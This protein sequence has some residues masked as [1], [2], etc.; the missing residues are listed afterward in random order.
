MTTTDLIS[1]VAPAPWRALDSLELPPFDAAPL[2]WHGIRTAHAALKAVRA[3]DLSGLSAGDWPTPQQALH[4]FL[5]AADGHCFSVEPHAWVDL[6]EP[7]IT[8][9][10]AHFLNAGSHSVRTRRILALLQAVQPSNSL[11]VDFTP[12]DVV[13]ARAISEAHCGAMRRF[14]DVIAWV[15]LRDGRRIGTVIEAK[16]GHEITDG[17]LSSYEAAA[18]KPPYSLDA[19]AARFVIVAPSLTDSILGELRQHPHRMWP[20][21]TQGWKF[22]AWRVLLTRLGSALAKSECDDDD[23]VRFRRTVWRCA[24]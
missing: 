5:G 8:K 3:G 9:G 15:Q 14:I 21:Q 18:A 6:H 1:A 4:A 7:Q 11:P 16:L 10:L 19:N 22:I 23:F 20:T 12:E 13:G 24:A 17:Q 2:R